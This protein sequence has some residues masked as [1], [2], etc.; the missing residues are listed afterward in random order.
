MMFDYNSSL[1]STGTEGLL[2]KQAHANWSFFKVRDYRLKK[3][4]PKYSQR[5]EEMCVAHEVE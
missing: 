1:S 3:E 5:K 4:K 2:E